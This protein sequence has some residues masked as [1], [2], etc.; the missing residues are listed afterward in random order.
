M[1]SSFAGPLL[2]ILAL[3]LILAGFYWVIRLAVRHA[4]KDADERR[5][6]LG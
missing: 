2:S 3:A 5:G 4:I 1:T 6:R